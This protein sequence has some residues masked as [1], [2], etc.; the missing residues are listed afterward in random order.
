ML[1]EQC[2]SW[3]GITSV[4]V[5][6]PLICFQPNNT[7]NLEGAKQTVQQFHQQMEAAG[8]Y[9]LTCSHTSTLFLIQTNLSLQ[10]NS[11]KLVQVYTYTSSYIID[12]TLPAS[13]Y[14]QG[15]KPPAGS[16]PVQNLVPMED[17]S[18]LL[19]LAGNCRLDIVVIS[20]V[21]K[22]HDLWAYPYN[23][24]RN[25]A[26]SRATTDVSLQPD[27]KRISLG[28]ESLSYW[29]G[30]VSR[31]IGIQKSSSFH[32]PAMVYEHCRLPCSL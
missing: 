7:E 6:W 1:E 23:A 18:S 20:E 17:S 14:V 26:L 8:S 15:P 3:M 11:I 10:F 19:W 25:Q 28:S 16:R 13:H 27:P 30:P 4:A 5:Y 32:K 31:D 12:T 22:E 29:A 24:L 21:I 9:L 2:K